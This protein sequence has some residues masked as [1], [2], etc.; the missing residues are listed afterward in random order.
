MQQRFNHGSLPFHIQ[1]DPTVVEIA[2][3]PEEPV[4]PGQ[5]CRKRAITDAL[6]NPAHDDMSANQ[7]LCS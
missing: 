6:H 2:D 4:L 3:S 7:L 1:L 5:S